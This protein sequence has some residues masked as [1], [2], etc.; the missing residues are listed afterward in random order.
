M[1][2]QP[3]PDDLLTPRH[4]GAIL[5]VCSRTLRLYTR[6]GILP[7]RRSAGGQN[8][9]F[10]RSEVDALRASRC[11]TTR[12]SVVLYARVSSHR[13]V[14]EGDL[15]RQIERL[16]AAA[17]D[18]PIA[19]TFSDVASGLCDR[20]Y[21][22]RGALAACAD[23]TVSEILVTHRECLARFGTGPLEQ[24]LAALGVTLTVIGEDAEIGTSDESELV[25]DMLSIV[26][27]FS[28][29]LY[30]QR[31]ERARATRRVMAEALA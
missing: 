1:P 4:A 13:Q 30:G 2:R 31:S 22:L 3:Q 18:R 29:R 7:D 19:G 23:P 27:S 16:R 12:R 28:G 11:A 25:R 21:G 17:S 20:R 14:A 24:M 5:G 9:V 6:D 10:L 8:R 15:A 26:T